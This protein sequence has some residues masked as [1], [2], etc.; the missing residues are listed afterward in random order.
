MA[1]P[2]QLDRDWVRRSFLVS[3]TNKDA[4]E[5]KRRFYSSASV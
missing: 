3:K 1:S 4:M 5:L 2:K